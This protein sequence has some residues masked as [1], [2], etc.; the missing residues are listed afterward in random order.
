[1]AAPLVIVESQA[2]AKTLKDQFGGDA[3][4][5]VVSSPPMKVSFSNGSD[6]AG[7]SFDF[8]PLPQEKA[9]IET[10]QDAKG[11]EI[12]LALAPDRQGEYWAWMINGYLAKLTGGATM[13]RCLRMLGLRRDEVMAGIKEASPVDTAAGE[14]YHTRM[15][16]N[17]AL[18]S[19]ILR[20]LGTQRGPNNLPLNFDSLTTI[21]FLVEREEE[22]SANSP[23]KKWQVQVNLASGTG[24]FSARLQNAP[25][26]NAEGFFKEASQGKEAVNLFKELLFEVASVER[27]TVLIPPPA[28]F[29][30]SE[31]LTDVTSRFGLDPRGV[32]AAV[33]LLFH[34]VEN[35][36]VFTGLISSFL[37]QDNTGS[38]E[39][40]EARIRNQAIKEYG[41]T[42]APGGAEPM[43][44]DDGF[45]LPLAPEITVA[46]LAGK[47]PSET[48]EIYELI[49]QRA[50]ASQMGNAEEETIAVTLK[51]GPE[52]RFLARGRV[53]KEKGFLVAYQ[54][55]GDQELL[56]DSPL[57]TLEIGRTASL[58]KITPEHTAGCP[59]EYYTFE[60][61]FADLA[62]LDMELDTTAVQMLHS[63]AA[64]GYLTIAPKGELRAGE[65][66]FKVA[67]VL[68]RL[69]PNMRSVN[70]SAYL[71]QTA[72]EVIDGRKGLGFALRQFD[73]TL[74]MQGKPLVQDD[75]SAKLRER[76]QASSR[77]ISSPQEM[78]PAQAEAAV[79]AKAAAVT[80]AT[81]AT[82]TAEAAVPKAMPASMAVEEAKPTAPAE[83]LE[84][85]PMPLPAVAAVAS[86]GATP[87]VAVA[88]PRAVT[89][90]SG[91]ILCPVCG[92]AV[93]I[94][95]RTPTGKDFFVCPGE[96]CEFMAWAKPHAVSC[97]VCHSPYLV[98]KK[99]IRG[100][101][102]L[103]CPRAGCNYMEPL[104]EE[105]GDSAA[106]T[107]A[108]G[109]KKRMVRRVVRKGT[110]GTR[111]VVVRRR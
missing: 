88:P 81:P 55:L 61:L 31:L 97:Q 94:N 24:E 74:T 44:G 82:P 92:K 8:S 76:K 69:F 35:N 11:R 38:L 111:R 14:A 95:K 16:F 63:M 34:G 107:D 60:S 28:P 12:F 30:L 62:D 17:A 87:M 100:Q 83:V 23:P 66:A 25:G 22:I 75:I 42:A 72:E 67:A 46:E 56:A 68:S 33:R 80:L 26:S 77:I 89:V 64:T 54:E 70:L 39:N 106:P 103:R 99:N 59:P 49:R 10:L 9:L 7:A 36:G 84:Q 85:E 71:K 98:E 43:T 37:P 5:V 41:S 52:C 65:N 53:F 48:L 91:G 27:E 6:S 32:L 102:L 3:E 73:Q 47:L 79:V 15:L 110:P 40:L 4:L 104:D 78:P 29:R 2:K 51:A 19:H 109:A 108:A 90:E 1:M 18:G 58:V 86:P 45:I 93:I 13:P 105:I 101:R 20:L 57:A 21:F 96:E 50:L